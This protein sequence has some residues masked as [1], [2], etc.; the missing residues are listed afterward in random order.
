MAELPVRLREMLRSRDWR[1]RQA[2]VEGIGS[3]GDSGGMVVLAAA[4]QDEDAR[5]S[6]ARLCTPSPGLMPVLR[7]SSI[8]RRLRQ[9]T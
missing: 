5:G 4:I 9:H 7:T 6:H 1:V 2:G 3:L 8:R